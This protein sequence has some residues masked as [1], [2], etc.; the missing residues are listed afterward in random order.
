[1][2]ENEAHLLP[3]SKNIFIEMHINNKFGELMENTISPYIKKLA[4]KEKMNAERM[5]AIERDRKSR[6]DFI[7]YGR[8]IR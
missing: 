1:M 2:S 8:R 5:P 4:W 3:I 7:I 6:M